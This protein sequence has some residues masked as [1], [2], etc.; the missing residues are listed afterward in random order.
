MMLLSAVASIASAA[1]PKKRLKNFVDLGS[2]VSETHPA[3]RSGTGKHLVTA[4]KEEIAFTFL[5]RVCNNEISLSIQQHASR[6]A[7]NSNH[8]KSRVKV[9][10]QQ[11]RRMLAARHAR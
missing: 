1:R 11:V 3:L 7:R 9:L 5:V 6:R 4:L 10:Q 2:L 8:V